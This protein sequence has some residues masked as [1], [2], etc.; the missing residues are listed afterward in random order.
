[1]FQS[2]YIYSKNCALQTAQ[3]QDAAANDT[4]KVLWSRS[5][6]AVEG[7]QKNIEVDFLNN[8]EPVAL[9]HAHIYA[10]EKNKFVLNII[11]IKINN[12]NFIYL[13]Y[14]ESRSLQVSQ[15]KIN[16]KIKKNKTEKFFWGQGLTQRYSLVNFFQQLV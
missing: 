10:H 12:L 6:Q 13:Q 15:I 2:N 11:G 8:R 7:E 9:A 5:I 4:S 3:H 14:F 16:D 1:M